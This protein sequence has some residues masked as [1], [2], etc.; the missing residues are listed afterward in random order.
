LVAAEGRLPSRRPLHSVAV[1]LDNGQLIYHDTSYDRFAYHGPAMTASQAVTIA[2][3]WLRRIGWA[4]RAMPFQGVASDTANGPAGPTAPLI[5][6][7]G[8]VG[9]GPT[10]A[11]EAIVSVAP[12]GRVVEAL[13]RPPVYRRLTVPTRDVMVVWKDV[14]GG[15]LPVAVQGAVQYPPPAA[16]GSVEEVRT[17]QMLVTTGKPWYLVPAYRFSG[18]VHLQGGQGTQSWYSLAPAA[19]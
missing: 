10:N 19:R 2:R 14:E 8:W 6:K 5:V 13:V 4:A 12:D 1:S 11:A 18:V 17:V 16:I 15:K 3:S 7:L 9:V